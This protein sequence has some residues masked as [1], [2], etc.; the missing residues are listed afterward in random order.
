MG[1]MAFYMQSESKN[2]NEI[3]LEARVT[4]VEERIV[5]LQEQI[6]QVFKM[7]REFFEWLKK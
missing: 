1:D 5:M 3:P 7:L 2:E 6:N 4:M